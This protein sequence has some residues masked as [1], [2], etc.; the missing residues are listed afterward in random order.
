MRGEVYIDRE[1]VSRPGLEPSKLR[2]S[3]PHS[4][5]LVDEATFLPLNVTWR[6]PYIST[7]SSHFSYYYLTFTHT[8]SPSGANELTA[9]SV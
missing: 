6:I 1:R 5:R 2:Q 9:A 3:V 7:R 8:L 4:D